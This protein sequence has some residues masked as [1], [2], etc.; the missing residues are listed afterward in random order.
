ME[1][2]NTPEAMQHFARAASLDP[3]DPYANL[4]LAFYAHRS[5]DL[6]RA[7]YYYQQALRSPRIFPA[8]K[9]QA[10]GNMGHVYGNLGTPSAPASLRSSSKHPGKLNPRSR[11]FQLHRLLE[12]SR[13]CSRSAGLWPAVLAASPPPANSLQQRTTSAV[14]NAYSVLS[15]V[16]LSGASAVFAFP[17]LLLRRAD[18]QSKDLLFAGRANSSGFG[19]MSERTTSRLT[20]R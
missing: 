14:P 1:Q 11:E 15:L 2:K 6:Q 8:D 12:N 18:P 9:R 3:T 7:L 17:P 16:I 19:D 13:C 4:E 20:G 5:G 10:L